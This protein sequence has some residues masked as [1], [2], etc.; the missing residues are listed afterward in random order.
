MCG[1]NC[2]EKAQALADWG[3][4]PRVRGKLLL[5]TVGKREAGITPACAGKTAAMS[6]SSI[7]SRDHP[8][9]CGENGSPAVNSTR[10]LGSPPR[11]RGKPARVAPPEQPAGITPAC[12][13]KTYQTAGGAPAGWDH[14]RVCGENQGRASVLPFYVVRLTGITPAC[15]GKTLRK[16]RISVVDPSPQ[17]QSSL[18]SRRAD[19][20]SGSQRAPCAA[21]V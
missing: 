11:V 12:A 9:V 10:C 3:S 7:R 1:E 4:P 6:S 2:W 8:R 16:W 18:T 15:A 5:Q 21:P 14:P 19:V 13:G 20:S 17:P